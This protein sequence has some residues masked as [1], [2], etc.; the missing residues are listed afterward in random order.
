M[1]GL[2]AAGGETDGSNHF[3]P[4]HT[5]FCRYVGQGLFRTAGYTHAPLDTP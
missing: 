4:M 3:S 2:C 5:E 1:I